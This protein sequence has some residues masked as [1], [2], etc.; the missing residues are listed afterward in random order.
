M[1]KI[2]GDELRKAIKNCLSEK[3][4]VKFAQ[5]IDCQIKLRSYDSKKDKRFTGIVKL[6]FDMRFKTTVCVI[7]DKKHCDAAKLLNIPH[8]SEKDLTKY[9]KEKKLTKKLAEDY[10]AFLASDSLIKKIPKILGPHLSKVGK[11]PTV[12]GTNDDLEKKV[13]EVQKMIKFQF[14]KEINL[15]VPVG[16][17]KMKEEEVFQNV[18]TAINAL[19]PLLKKQWQ[20]VGSITI[21][22][23][24]GKPQRIYPSGNIDMKN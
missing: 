24:M 2:S 1:S 6:P 11:F 4:K 8:L 20:N 22:P 14:K 21:K 13:Q 12:V 3:D 15:G 23:T 19:V 7:G 10:H 17:V 16:H 5:T 18:V 9:Q